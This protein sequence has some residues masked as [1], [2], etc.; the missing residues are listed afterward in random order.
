MF[1][2]VGIKRKWLPGYKKYQVKGHRTEAKITAYVYGPGGKIIEQ[3]PIEHSPT[4]VLTMRD[5]SQLFIR[6]ILEREWKLYPDYAKGLV[7][8][9]SKVNKEAGDQAKSHLGSDR[10]APVIMNP[11]PQGG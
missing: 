8:E 7:E 11:A 9:M 1:Y 3:M 2:T 6:N 4:L 5:E 10:S